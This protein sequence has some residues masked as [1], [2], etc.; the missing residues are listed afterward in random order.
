M[1]FFGHGKL[2]ILLYYEYCPVNNYFHS[3]LKLQH[4]D[5]G[6]FNVENVSCL[7]ESLCC[8]I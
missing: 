1:Y 7:L 2:F 3:R 5:C 8:A 6:S 4:G